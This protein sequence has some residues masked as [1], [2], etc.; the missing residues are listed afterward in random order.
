MPLRTMARMTA[1]SPGQSPP[2]VS[3]PIRMARRLSV[4][5]LRRR[6]VVGLRQP[7]QLAREVPVALAEQL[8]GCREQH[9]THDRGVDQARHGQADAHLLELDHAQA[10]ED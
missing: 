10:R 9:R 8:H 5:G 6:L 7:A 1:L 2:P 3:T 4:Y